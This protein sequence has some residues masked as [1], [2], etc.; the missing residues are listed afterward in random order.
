MPRPRQPNSRTLI[1]AFR[2]TPPELHALRA[3]AEK[4]GITVSDLL[5][6]TVLGKPD[7]VNQQHS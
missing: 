7:G 1:A 6:L 4:Q 5:R 3:S 2:V